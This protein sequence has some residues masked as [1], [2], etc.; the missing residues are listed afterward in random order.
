VHWSG[1]FAERI[2]VVLPREDCALYEA[3]AQY[4]LG[5]EEE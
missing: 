3:A 1:S 2:R 4:D 5:S